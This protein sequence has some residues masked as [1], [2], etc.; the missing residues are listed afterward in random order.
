VILSD[1]LKGTLPDT[2]AWIRH[3]R[4][5]GTPVLVDSKNPG[6]DCRGADLATPNLHEAGILLGRSLNA[7]GLADQASALLA[8][9]GTRAVLVTLGADGMLLIQPHRRPVKLPAFG[10]GVDPTGGGDTVIAAVAAALAVGANM[11]DAMLYAAH[12]AALVVARPGTT[13]ASVCE[14]AS[15]IDAD[16]RVKSWGY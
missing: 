7:N 16:A 12:A 9:L 2:A 1:Y 11:E 15:I 6:A 14:L 10:D 13:V 8:R 5:N 4:D 3:C